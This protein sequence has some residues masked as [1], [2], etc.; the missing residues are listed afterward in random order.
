[1]ASRLGPYSPTECNGILLFQNGLVL[2]CLEEG[3]APDVRW[4]KTST[5]A[6]LQI[7]EPKDVWRRQ[8]PGSHVD[9]LRELGTDEGYGDVVD[10]TALQAIVAAGAAAASLMK[11]G[12]RR[13][14]KSSKKRRKNTRRRRR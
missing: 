12:G 9:A 8:D 14:R 10:K 2:K 13:K 4:F 5:C 1:M 7:M 6:N 11:G 3:R